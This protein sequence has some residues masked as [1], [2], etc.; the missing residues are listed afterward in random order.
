MDKQTSSSVAPSL[1]GAVAA[2][3]A[4]TFSYP[5]APAQPKQKS[6]KDGQCMFKPSDAM[7]LPVL[8]N[9]TCGISC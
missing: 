5:T 1:P 4:L 9:A 7:S 3:P 8:L 6:A 2:A